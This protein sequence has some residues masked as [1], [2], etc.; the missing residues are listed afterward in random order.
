MITDNRLKLFVALC[1]SGS[2]TA[3]ARRMGCS[4]PSVSQNVAQLES[5][6]GC[7]LFNRGKNILPT[8]AGLRFLAYARRILSLYDKLDA[9]MRGA[10][11]LPEKCSLDLGHG[12][13][14]EV[15][16][17]EGKLE[18]DLKSANN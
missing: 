9:E 12:R 14:A 17:N 1:E 5:E 3:A 10:E 2:F 6:V 11:V 13:T 4:Q 7:K 16:V 8:P 18:I 15:T